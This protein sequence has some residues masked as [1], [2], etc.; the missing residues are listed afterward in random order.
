MVRDDFWLAASRF[1]RDLEIRLVEGEN[2]RLSWICLTP[3]H[4]T[5]SADRVWPGN[6]LGRCRKMRR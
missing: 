1:M 2:K 5:E 3:D 4:A 6:R